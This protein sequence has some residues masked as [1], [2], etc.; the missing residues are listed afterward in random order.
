[1]FRSMKLK[2]IL[3]SAI[4]VLAT[5]CEEYTMKSDSELYNSENVA[6]VD[7]IIY[8]A[9]S[10][11]SESSDISDISYRLIPSSEVPEG[12]E[13]IVLNNEQELINLL[14]NIV[15]IKIRSVNERTEFT[16]NSINPIKTRSELPGNAS[17]ISTVNNHEILVTC[18]WDMLGAPITVYTTNYNTWYFQEW[19]HNTG[20]GGWANNNTRINY[21][22]TG[23]IITFA[24]VNG[25]VVEIRREHC[26][27]NGYINI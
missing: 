17:S 18:S 20:N 5:S 10:E 23:S 12:I 25:Y 21:D 19:R 7:E 11:T 8:R 26:S 4:F 22:Y 3:F 2:I 13:P 14:Q 16:L 27:G 1:M 9:I 15:K 24:Y 6:E